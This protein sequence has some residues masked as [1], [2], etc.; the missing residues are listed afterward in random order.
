MSIQK[1]HEELI[2][3][4]YKELE[5]LKNEITQLEDIRKNIEI[6]ISGNKDLPPLFL[7]LYKKLETMSVTY[8]E[9]IDNITRQYLADAN[10]YFVARL[11]ELQTEIVNLKSQ[12]ERISNFNFTGLFK[13]LQKVFIDQTRADLAN[14][15]NKFEEKSKDLQTKIDELNKQIVR[16]EKIDLEKHFDKLQETLAGIFGAI[17]AI[18]LSLTNVIQTLT[19]IVQ[20][21]GNI[22]TNLEVN[23][24][25]AKQLL[26]IFSETTYKQLFAIEKQ[27]KEN[28]ELLESKIKYIS[29]QNDLLR[30]GIKTNRIIHIL[31]YGIIICILLFTAF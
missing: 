9:G 16:L 17:N 8:T 11:I 19:G 30:K 14:E 25:E 13:D 20:A 10:T 24:K 31:A 5:I 3:S 2:E 7:E 23:H 21:L 6:L 29:I 15:L 4:S 12:I 28:L 1:K 22:Q 18:N 27:A 26:N